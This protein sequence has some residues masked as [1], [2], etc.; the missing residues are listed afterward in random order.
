MKIMKKKKQSKIENQD[1]QIDKTPS[2]W[3]AIAPDGLKI[4]SED[5][6]KI[7]QS[8]GTKTYFRPFYIPRDGY[9]RKMATNWINS[10][11]SS[12]EVDVLVDIHKIPKNEA[13]RML[14]TQLTILRSNL[15]FQ[16]KRGNIDQIQDI[17]T[18]IF[19]T[20]ALMAE[21]QFNENDCFNVSVLGNI[22]APSK[23]ELDRYSES[24]EDEMT[25]M[26]FSIA[27]AWHRIKKGYRS[28]L[29]I[30][31][32]EIPDSMRNIDRRALSTFAPF[33][34]GSGKYYGG[35]PI[36]INKI[37]GQ[38][39]F[40]N[41][42]GT[43]EYRPHNY[44]VG[45]LGSSGSGKSTSMKV[46]ISREMAG[47]N[48]YASIIDVEGEFC[49]LTK[50]LGGINLDIAEESNIII[51]PLAL[52]YTEIQLKEDD[53]ELEV[54]QDNDAKELIER[55]GK[56]YI[57]FVPIREKITEAISFFDIIAR[58]K[59]GKD[60]GLSV[61]ERNYIEE[62]MYK[63]YEDLGIHS[64]PSS[65]FINK[66]MEQNGSIIQSQVRKMEPTISDV[67]QYIIHHYNEEPKAERLIA[68]IRPFL[69]TGSKP[70][71][72]GQTYLGNNVTQTLM[73]A[74][75]INFNISQLEEGFLRPIA[76]HTILNFLWEY[77]AKSS[78]NAL[79][80]KYI[81]ADEM[82]MFVDND[83]T[84]S[85]LEKVARRSRKRNCGLC[86]ASQ[87]FVRI[88]AN[89]KARGIIQNTYTFMF[90]R[91]NTI[92]RKAIEENF[93]LSRGERDILF[94]NPDKGEG[95]LRIGKSSVWIQVNPSQDEM[96]FLESNTAV[97]EELLRKRR[98]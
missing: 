84:C 10:I 47:A 51:N 31:N 90:F 3:D 1:N 17:E 9:P 49:D 79:K 23:K 76:Y 37:T 85:F 15:T 71:F 62:A 58:G 29:P 16:R 4:N 33:I 70:I 43:E 77:F 72:D 59:D 63:I 25:G 75:L 67:Y 80:K 14:Q 61:F 93:D 73:N 46:K 35:I 57:R 36:G 28:V 54:L 11:T 19:D 5:Y 69:K 56:K 20:E 42:F 34:S 66:V 65:L 81:Y 94:G 13:M 86:W 92:D 60:E 97:L 40:F 55:D 78:E 44:N 52:N 45:I 24:L 96:V 26:F 30:G 91:Q 48:I 50:R 95:I 12:G 98:Q 88:L 32:N 89:P 8:L 21:L 64:H 82:W 39:E 68:A 18:R 41:S 2:F 83:E 6:G 7:K 22:Y 53:E 27:T 74:R 87:D 38:L